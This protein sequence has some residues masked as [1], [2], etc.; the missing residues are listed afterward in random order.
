MEKEKIQGV[1]TAE[2]AELK[3]QCVLWLHVP[4]CA[5]PNFAPT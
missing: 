3:E 2:V 1:H 4:A 5:A